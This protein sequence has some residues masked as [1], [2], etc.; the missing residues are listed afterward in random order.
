MSQR[1]LEVLDGIDGPRLAPAAHRWIGALPSSFSDVEMR[2]D[3]WTRLRQLG[4]TDTRP[5]RE[6]DRTP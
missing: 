6:R 4:L 5:A 2:T 3:T 1:R